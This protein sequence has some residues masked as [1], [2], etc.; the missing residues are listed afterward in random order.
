MNTSTSTVAGDTSANNPKPAVDEVR[1]KAPNEVA[2]TT[3]LHVPTTDQ[4][5]PITDKPAQ[6]EAL[7][8]LKA[9]APKVPAAI[10]KVD[11]LSDD[12]AIELLALE[13]VIAEG[14]NSFVQVGLAL[15]RIRDKELFRNEYE[16]FPAYYRA[17]WQLEHSYVYYLIPAAQLYSELATT[18]GVPK[19][20]HESQLRP[21]LGVPKESAA[22]AWKYAA[23]LSGGRKI[24]GRLVKRA[25]RELK[26]TPKPAD[27]E[28]KLVREKR[29]QHR[30][31]MSGLISE[32]VTM[33]TKKADHPQLLAKVEELNRHFLGLFAQD[34]SHKRKSQSN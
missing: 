14:W 19:P 2:S 7:A 24:T 6:N 21:L 1:D 8:R 34:R 12:E 28:K 33:L 9:A 15:A 25:I 22:G 18:P 16:S 20:E 3:D 23:E 5:S 30:E 32:L 13:A 27:D 10:G 31:A 26:L 29:S 11:T 4:R 17:K